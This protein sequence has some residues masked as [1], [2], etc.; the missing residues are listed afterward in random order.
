MSFLPFLS[1]QDIALSIPQSLVGRL[2]AAVGW[3]I[4]AVAILALAWRWR[5]YD[6]PRDRRYLLIF[7]VL[8]L[9]V[10]L[11]SLFIG[12]QILVPQ[13]LS[14]YL[15]PVE[16]VGP[17]LM[18]FSAL[19]WMLAGGLLGPV[20]AAGIAFLAGIIQALWDTHSLF[21][22]LELAFLA[23]LFGV[24]MHQRFRTPFFRFLR[25]P[26]F[27]ALLC[28]LIY[29]MLFILSA[30]LASDGSLANRL[31]YAFT[32][33]GPFSLAM[34]GELLLG[35]LFAEVVALG[36]PAYWGG[37]G[38]LVSSPGENSLQARFFVAIAPLLIILLLTVL[39]VDW[40]MAGK[41]ARQIL[42]G[43]MRDAALMASKAIPYFLDV[44]QNETAKLASEVGLASSSLEELNGILAENMVRVP[45]FNQ[46]YVLDTNGRTIASYPPGDYERDLPDPVEQMGIR[47]AVQGVDN[48]I[49]SISPRRDEKTAQV[50]FVASILDESNQP[51]GVLVARAGLE[52]NPF[53]APIITSLQSMEAMGGEGVL[54]DENG[55]ILY[56][57]NPELLMEAYTGQIPDEA[58]F[59]DDTGPDGT[60]RLV[61][62][63]PSE[64]RPWAVVLSTPAQQ[65]QQI[66][67]N[68]SAPLL[69]I[70]VILAITSVVLLRL[71]LKAIN[72]SLQTLATQADV[73]ARGNLD[74]VLEI[75]GEDEVGRLRRSFE[76]M[77]VSLK[78]RLEEINRLLAVVQ[79]VASNLDMTKAVQPVLESALSSG[80]SSARVVLDPTM[81]PE[82]EG[83]SKKPVVYYAGPKQ[84]QYRYLDEQVMALTRQQDRLVINNVLRPRLLHFPA[85]VSRPESILAVALRHEN[86]YYGALW[87][88]YDQPHSISE[89]ELR[90][91]VTLAGQAALAAANARLFLNSEIGRQ[92]LSAILASTPDPV[93]V[94]DQMNRL[95]LA[96]PAA[97]QV[98][99]LGVEWDE[100]RAIT[101]LISQKE[102]V[103]LMDSKTEEKR[104][105]EVRLADGRIYYATASSVFAEGH[106]VGRVCVM[107]DITNFKELDA[108][109]SEFVATVS[110]D[111]RSPLT[112]MRGYAS[113]LE[114]V[115][116]LNDQQTGFVRKM[117]IGVE[118]MSQLVNDL[119]D[120]GRIDAGI[121][122]RIDKVSVR[123]LIERVVG[124]SQGQSAQGHVQLSSEIPQQIPPFLE[125]D[126]AL[127]QQ[128]LH[129]LLENAIKFTGPG[130]KVQV[131][132]EERSREM[133]FIVNDTGT[134]IPPLDLPRLFEKFYRGAGQ[135]GKRQQGTGLGLA[136]VKSIADR[137]EGRVWVDSLLGKGSTFYFAIP[138]QHSK[139]ISE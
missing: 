135:G 100:G 137:H 6:K 89:E 46:F 95:L 92:R 24:A 107:R 26:L 76:Q 61:Y 131:R 111:L 109:K 114:I 67:L 1:F 42:E 134:G 59:F 75:T 52:E 20:G 53:T 65:V 98:I 91:A 129:N 63:Q 7:C 81:V 51:W 93:L 130:G 72:T 4:F 10:P 101:D 48:Q 139:G 80:A 41:A 64:G 56:H 30:T 58:S 45:F 54:L 31:D 69:V 110:H 70:I 17:A 115:G 38:E 79:G 44:G 85:N 57:P 99:G 37:K 108:L 60:R 106:R 34:A 128:A 49:Y 28:S 113:M 105:A 77:R 71:R 103:A 50:S 21:M 94:T 29:P 12:V 73:I 55:R 127:L 118:N 97:W 16:V 82:L 102:L 25:H 5:Q 104:S 122:L 33:V 136:I 9:V 125:A 126:S 22:P 112:L 121:G 84:D 90:F 124:A 119:L 3:L 116:D 18:V 88:A 74:Q 19:P 27:G 47:Q 132:V 66:A 86:Q 43:R 78:M 39:V 120:L 40:I 117:V 13:S 68:I 83:D 8:A 36:L 133:V 11:T 23:L 2:V 32:L 138:I 14:P 35:G 96:N 15:L 123:D 87:I 62:Y